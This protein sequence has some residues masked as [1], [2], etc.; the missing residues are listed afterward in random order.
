MPL[1]GGFQ[2][3]VWLGPHQEP[4]PQ[5][6]GDFRTWRLGLGDFPQEHTPWGPIR[7]LSPAPD[8]TSC[9]AYVHLS[10]LGTCM[11]PEKG[12]GG[13]PLN[14]V[15]CNVSRFSYQNC[16]G[17]HMIGYVVQVIRDGILQMEEGST[18]D[19]GAIRISFF[20]SVDLL[21]YYCHSQTRPSQHKKTQTI[22]Q[23]VSII[24]RSC[25]W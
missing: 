17:T 5:A 23:I 24:L 22:R 18:Y 1:F 7:H 4:H 12:A 15:S 25:V 20:V 9:T 3:D 11:R 10:V 19:E 21:R 16:C 6:R 14:S 8:S 2:Q 13:S